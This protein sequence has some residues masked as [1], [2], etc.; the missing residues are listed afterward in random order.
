MTV[1]T[2]SV[3]AIVILLLALAVVDSRMLPAMPLARSVLIS[4]GAAAAGS[5]SWLVLA[6]IL[7]PELAGDL[8]LPLA[9][10]AGVAAFIATVAVRASGARLVA[11]LAFALVWSATVFVPTAIISF[12]PIGVFGLEP[13]DH[14]GSLP[15]NVASGAAALGVLLAVGA[16]APRARTLPLPRGL[17]AAAVL[18]LCAG[19]LVWLVGAELAVDEVSTLILVNGVVGSAGGIAGWLTVQRISHQST[20]LTAVAGGAVS[21]LVAIT[22]GAPLY[23]PVSAAAAGVIAG[24]AACLFTLR[25]VGSARRPQ[26]FIVGSHLIAGAIGVVLLGMLASGSGFLFTGQVLFIGQQ[27]LTTVVVAV[28]SIVVA[29]LLWAAVRRIPR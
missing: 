14:G 23:T 6:P 20:T 17:G 12:G 4:V 3:V 10:L 1:T 5:L 18:A 24:G 25:R 7:V 2:V 16:R 22:A 27:L 19:W 28:Y 8:Y 29:F 26:W 11:T 21:G 15:L 9:A 13:I